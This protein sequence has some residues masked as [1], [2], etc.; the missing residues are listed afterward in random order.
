MLSSKTSKNSTRYQTS[1]LR[2]QSSRKRLSRQWSCR[3]ISTRVNRG[4][5]GLP[6]LQRWLGRLMASTTPSYPLDSFLR[7]QQQ[8]FRWLEIGSSTFLRTYLTTTAT[9]TE[10][11][12][13]FSLH[14]RGR[15]RAHARQ[16]SS[17]GSEINPSVGEIQAGIGKVSWGGQGRPKDDSEAP[18]AC[19]VARG[20][21]VPA[22]PFPIKPSIQTQSAIREKPMKFVELD[23]RGKSVPAKPRIIRRGI[24]QWVFKSTEPPSGVHGDRVWVS[25]NDGNSAR[26][27]H[28]LIE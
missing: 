13:D 1:L 28:T 10:M 12:K 14:Y 23:H 27:I 11:T 25:N 22:E 15:N 9:K 16:Q 20:L 2:R 4:K 19:A 17:L 7:V 24:W 6:D 26:R 5:T 21:G 18:W 8:V 3:Y